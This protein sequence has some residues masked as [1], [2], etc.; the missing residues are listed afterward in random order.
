MARRVHDHEKREM[1]L[2]FAANEYRKP[3]VNIGNLEYLDQI[4]AMLKIKCPELPPGRTHVC[5]DAI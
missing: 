2:E 1:F 5:C 3:V 4:W